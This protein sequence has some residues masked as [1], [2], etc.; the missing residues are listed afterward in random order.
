MEPDHSLPLD[1]RFKRRVQSWL[2]S[3]MLQRV[4]S[5]KLTDVSEV[6]N[7]AIIWATSASIISSETVVSFYKTTLTN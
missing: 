2:F 5:Q 4:V 1:F 6:R 7:D 3:G